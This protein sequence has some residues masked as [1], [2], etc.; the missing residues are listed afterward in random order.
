MSMDIHQLICVGDFKYTRAIF[1][2]DTENC[3]N[4]KAEYNGR[5]PI[6]FLVKKL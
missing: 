3:N 5:A 1:S 6:G 4:Q 2:N